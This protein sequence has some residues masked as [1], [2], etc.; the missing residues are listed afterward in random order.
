MNLAGCC[1]PCGRS[2]LGVS[3]EIGGS[4]TTEIRKPAASLVLHYLEDWT[5]PLAE[6]RRVSLGSRV[7]G[8]CTCRRS[9]CSL[10]TRAREGLGQVQEFS[11]SNRPC[12]ALLGSPG[13]GSASRSGCLAGSRLPAPGIWTTT[14]SPIGSHLINT[15]YESSRSHEKLSEALRGEWAGLNVAHLGAGLLPAAL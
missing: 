1:R 6:L 11:A 3:G 13:G 9:A 7:T 5:E 2:S 8:A 4:L 12:S 14:T 15:A 10:K